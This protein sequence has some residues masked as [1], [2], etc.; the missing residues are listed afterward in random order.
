MN[1]L[2]IRDAHPDDF[3]NIGALHAISW[4]TTYRGLIPDSYLND[5]LEEERRKY[6]KEKLL[7]LQPREFVLVAEDEGSLCGFVAVLD[8]PENGYDALIDNLHVRPDVKG[9]GIGGK[10]LNAVAKRLKET[11]RTTVYLWV[12]NGNDAAAAFYLAKG[13]TAAD[14]GTGI[15]GGHVVGE[16][17]YAWNSLDPL[18]EM[19]R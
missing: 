8:K 3:K 19:E 1:A 10:L 11:G 18:M 9:K 17:R 4:L 14:E 13:A 16:R 5:Q 6:W 12:L 7:S 15:F 2:Q